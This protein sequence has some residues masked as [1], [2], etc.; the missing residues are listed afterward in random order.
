MGNNALRNTNGS[1]NTAIGNNA[2]VL[3]TTGTNNTAIGGYANFGANNLTNATALGYGATVAASNTIQLGA[4]GSNSTTAITN[5]KTSGTITAGTVTYPNT[6]G[7][8]NQV[9]STT[10]SGT[11]AWTTPATGLPSSGNTAGDMLYW[12]GSA[13]VKVAAGSNGQT[14]T[15]NNGAPGWSNNPFANTIVSNKTGKTWMDR[16]LGASQVATS[17]TDHLAYGSFYQ[18]GRGSDGHELITW[19]SST[20]GTPVNGTTTTLSSS[21]V[22]GNALF[23]LNISSPFDWRSGQNVNLWQGVSGTNNPCPAGFR[24]PTHAEWEAESISWSASTSV[25]AFASPL[26]LPM[27]GYHQYNNGLLS[28][29]GTSGGYWS[30]TVSGTYSYYLIFTSSNVLTGTFQRAGGMSV[31]CIKD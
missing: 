25:G 3:N 2:G 22:P 15:F 27:T 20:T 23:I 13:W 21:D 26:K 5:V 10:G 12:N 1:E 30:S 17:S 14:L 7:S 28:L 8:A 16:N 19:S 6:H 18:W 4:D 11:L 29:I 9:L 24:I 31:R